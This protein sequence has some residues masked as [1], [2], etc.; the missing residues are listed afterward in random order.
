MNKT[1]L[2]VVGI[3]ILTLAVGTATSVSELIPSAHA[4]KTGGQTAQA[5]SHLYQYKLGIKRLIK[6]SNHSITRIRNRT[7]SEQQART[8]KGRSHRLLHK[9]VQYCYMTQTAGIR[10]FLIVSHF[11]LAATGLAIWIAYLATDNDTLAWIA[12]LILAVVALLG[13]TMFAVWYQRRRRAARWLRPSIRPLP[14]SS[15]SRSG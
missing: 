13:W 2:L 12:F 10:P 7:H 8:I 3:A 11:L 4:K 15:T 14:P 5:Q 9:D 6:L 1:I